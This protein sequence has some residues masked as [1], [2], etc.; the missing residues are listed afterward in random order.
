[1][2]RQPT[3]HQRLDHLQLGDHRRVQPL[4]GGHRHGQRQLEQPVVRERD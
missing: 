4:A 3:A 2:G 1:M